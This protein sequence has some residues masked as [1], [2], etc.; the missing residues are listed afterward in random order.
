[1]V[2][3]SNLRTELLEYKDYAK[4]SYLLGNVGIHKL[5]NLYNPESIQKNNHIVNNIEQPKTIKSE[6][7]NLE[8][9]IKYLDN[10]LEQLKNKR[11]QELTDSAVPKDIDNPF[12]QNLLK[13]GDMTSDVLSRAKHDPRD[14]PQRLMLENWVKHKKEIKKKIEADLAKKLAE[15]D[16]QERTKQM[17]LERRK[18]R[19]KKLSDMDEREKYIWNERKLKMEAEFGKNVLKNLDSQLQ[20]INGVIIDNATAAKEAKNL[21]IKFIRATNVFEKLRKVENDREARR[22]YYEEKMRKREVALSAI[23]VKQQKKLRYKLMALDIK[24]QHEVRDFKKKMSNEIAKVLK[25]KEANFKAQKILMKAIQEKRELELEEK[26]KAQLKAQAALAASKR[27]KEIEKENKKQIKELQEQLGKKVTGSQAFLKFKT[28]KERMAHLKKLI[29]KQKTK[30]LADRNKA[31]AALLA[32]R[33][34][35]REKKTALSKANAIV[36]KQKRKLKSSEASMK[37]KEAQIRRQMAADITNKAKLEENSARK[38]IEQAKFIALK[39]REALK[40]GKAEAKIMSQKAIYRA[41]QQA[42]AATLAKAK[43]EKAKALR[44]LAERMDRE[45]KRLTLEHAKELE[46]KG[47]QIK[48]MQQKFKVQADVLRKQ[49]DIH[50]KVMKGQRQQM[51]VQ[52]ESMQKERL[53]VQK[54]AE[55]KRKRLEKEAF[56]RKG[57][58][59][60]KMAQAQRNELRLKAILVK[61]KKTSARRSSRLEAMLKLKG[62]SEKEAREALIRAEKARQEVLKARNA[63][64]AQLREKLRL[65][66]FFVAQEKELQAKK[67]R[68]EEQKRYRQYQS[69][70]KKQ[71]KTTEKA[72]QAKIAV[73]RREFAIKVQKKREAEDKAKEDILRKEKNKLKAQFEAE[74]KKVKKAIK[75]LRIAQE[76]SIKATKYK[77]KNIYL[78]MKLSGDVKAAKNNMKKELELMKEQIKKEDEARRKAE[79]LLRNAKN[80]AEK[81][82]ARVE[83]KFAKEQAELLRDRQKFLRQAERQQEEKESQLKLHMVK[84]GE[85]KIKAAEKENF[86][87]ISKKKALKAKQN[88]KQIRDKALAENEAKKEER[89][90]QTLRFQMRQKELLAAKAKIKALKKTKAAQRANELKKKAADMEN[91]AN[92]EALRLKVQAEMKKTALGT[93]LKRKDALE[94]A[95]KLAKT[96]EER[97]LIIKQIMESIERAKKA[98]EE[99]KN[100]EF[101]RKEAKA[102]AIAA[103]TEARQAASYAREQKSAAR[104]AKSNVAKRDKAVEKAKAYNKE[105]AEKDAKDKAV[106]EAEAKAKEAEKANIKKQTQIKKE[107]MKKEAELMKQKQLKLKILLKKAKAK[108]KAAELK[109]LKAKTKAQQ[110]VLAESVYASKAAA[111]K[112]KL[113]GK[114]KAKYVVIRLNKTKNLYLVEVQ[115]FENNIDVAKNKLTKQ[116]STP[117]QNNSSDK[118]ID[119]EKNTFTYTNNRNASWRINLDG[120]FKIDTINIQTTDDH[121]TQKLKNATVY[122]YDGNKKILF[123]KNLQGIV[124]QKFNVSLKPKKSI[125]VEESKQSITNY[126]TVAILGN[127]SNKYCM[128]NYIRKRFM[129]DGNEIETKHKFHII[130]LNGKKNIKSGDKIL[131]RSM[132]KK[133]CKSENNK[134]RVVCNA[135]KPNS[136]TVFTIINQ[137]GGT[138]HGNDLIILRAYNDTYCSEQSSGQIGCFSK[139]NPTSKLFRIRLLEKGTKIGEKIQLDVRKTS[140][141]LVSKISAEMKKMIMD[142]YKLTETQF[143]QLIKMIRPIGSSSIS[144]VVKTPYQKQTEGIT[145]SKPKVELTSKQRKTENLFLIGIDKNFRIWRKKKLNI[146]KSKWKKIKKGNNAG[147][148]SKIHFNRKTKFFYGISSK[149]FLLKKTT[150]SIGSKWINLGLSNVKYVSS[151]KNY[152]YTIDINNKIYRKKISQIKPKNISLIEPNNGWKQLKDDSNIK[153]KAIAFDNNIMHGINNNSLFQKQ[154]TDVNS[155]W[156]KIEG[157]NLLDIEFRTGY[158]F[159]IGKN[160][161]VYRKLKRDITSKW[162]NYESC[163]L[164]SFTFGLYSKAQGKTRQLAREPVREPVKQSARQLAREPVREPV[165]QSA[166]QPVKQS[167]RQPARE[168]VREP[169]REQAREPAREQ[170]REPAREPAREQ[171][172]E[173]AREQA[174]ELARQPAREQAR[175]LARQP[176]RQPARQRVRQQAEQAEQPE[177]QQARQRT[178]T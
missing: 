153:I 168:L 171:A 102:K 135:S 78:A 45:K 132:R 63:K 61:E 141:T 80:E 126:S 108:E 36:K 26:R 68:M 123:K 122:V 104:Q 91:R 176:A 111:A 146:Q 116:S 150:E 129:C 133:Y 173:P 166:R 127:I 131:L 162:V 71:R 156:T 89:K 177:R 49:A 23:A 134:K 140:G 119:G 96:E 98:K 142:E 74:S 27:Q 85:A 37:K 149:N 16:K 35:L 105:K 42:I 19:D 121:N 120:Y 151:N 44:F 147:N 39:I 95:K 21:L 100:A 34:E 33:K 60:A 4:Q 114:G 161:K 164:L 15:Q 30:I 62:A 47:K 54:L 24:R 50:R 76:D 159:G 145:K 90:L 40:Q 73:Q 75:N 41:R 125:L 2:H 22:K 157:I 48:K 52:K 66:A 32:A 6:K 28:D 144:A 97:Q 167:A 53:K 130:R 155:S 8:K 72:F 128:D 65:Q 169:A 11:N 12:I 82:K 138:I 79:N 87:N 93:E 7:K 57:V 165:K 29:K 88:R 106:R 59:I 154:L 18:L 20:N 110:N 107:A 92:L 101:E 124:S 67:I 163:C 77:T 174:R 9:K 94:I 136:K 81:E 58:L 172:R 148:I 118:A 175:E 115:I 158:L 14:N 17:F 13:I 5:S 99:A 103:K 112:A 31:Q 84:L 1:M 43:I 69:A 3:P 38:A 143:S 139:T 109:A 56:R 137:Y 70:M 83:A 51:R 113:Q 152:L 117:S 46:E 170:A 160:K 178:R 64:E 25:K 55:E 86:V 10:L